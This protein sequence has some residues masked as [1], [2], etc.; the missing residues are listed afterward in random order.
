MALTQSNCHH[1]GWAAGRGHFCVALALAPCVPGAPVSVPRH[2]PGRSLGALLSAKELFVLAPV[3]SGSQ[4]LLSSELCRASSPR[5]QVLSR[6]SRSA[7]GP[8]SSERIL[9]VKCKHVSFEGISVPRPQGHRVAA[10]RGRA[11]PWLRKSWDRCRKT[12]VPSDPAVP[13][14][15][16]GFKEIGGRRAKATFRGVF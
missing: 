14:P 9:E 8:Q 4:R 7:H 2:A 10:P 12:V 15:G 1:G 6:R 3:V 11:C 5:H 16:A 13:P